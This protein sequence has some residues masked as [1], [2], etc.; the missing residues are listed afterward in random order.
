[1][2]ADHEALEAELELL[3]LEA[4]ATP[5]ARSRAAWARAPYLVAVAQINAYLAWIEREVRPLIDRLPY[6]PD[7]DLDRR[8]PRTQR[9]QHANRLRP[10]IFDRRAQLLDALDWLSVD[11]PRCTVRAITRSPL[12]EVEVR[13]TVEEAGVSESPYWWFHPNEPLPPATSIRIAP[14]R[15]I[16]RARGDHGRR[17]RR[18]GRTRGPPTGEDEDSDPD[19]PGH[20]GGRRSRWGR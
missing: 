14:R 4:P 2:A 8:S 3:T 1:M 5:A 7:R 20:V 15:L 17:R 11:R 13:Y 6:E 16:V 10:D 9:W 12:I 19:G 18:P